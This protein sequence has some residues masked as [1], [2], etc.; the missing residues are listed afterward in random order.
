[1]KKFINKA[2]HLNLK[3]YKQSNTLESQA[4]LEFSEFYQLLNQIFLMLAVLRRS[5]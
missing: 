1:M 3:I 5:E 4:Y 2:T